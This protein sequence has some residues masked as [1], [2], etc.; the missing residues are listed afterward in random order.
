MSTSEAGRRAEVF[1]PG[2]ALGAACVVFVASLAALVGLSRYLG[3]VPGS[4][5]AHYLDVLFSADTG[6]R[7]LDLTEPFPSH[8]PIAHLLL[9]HIW[10]KPG[11]ALTWASRFVW[12]GDAGRFYGAVGLVCSTAAAGFACLWYCALRLNPRRANLW[13][14]L[15]VCLLFTSNAIIVQPDHFGLS[16]GL[17]SLA[18]LAMLPGARGVGRG[19]LLGL[20]GFLCAVT[21]LT[22][23]LYP[24]LVAA[25][26]H[27][28][29]LT[30]ANAR[31]FRYLI[32]AVA[33]AGALVVVPV[34]VK[35]LPS[36]LRPTGSL[37]DSRITLYLNT[38][39]FSDP[40]GA[41]RYAGSGLLYPAVG[42]SPSTWTSEEDGHVQP[43][44]SY[45]TSTL[46]DYGP[47]SAAA[48]VAWLAL[49]AASGW[50][51]V[52]SPDFRNFSLALL[53]WIVFNLLF[54]NLWGDEFFLF[55][56]HW[57]WALILVVLLGSRGLPVWSVA[58]AALCIIP[59]QLSTLD[60]IRRLLVP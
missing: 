33:A 9:D 32:L 24:A 38:R 53:G 25:V 15:P 27:R 17:V 55:S 37:G 7:W 42:P 8:F 41:L 46:G 44:V 48:A 2:A 45:E 31:R 22:N 30:W 35:R 21:T 50:S 58:L 26:V 12:P 16:F 36:L 47:L 5:Y 59:G 49:L 51:L 6:V 57:S 60:A 4:P 40:L 29:R 18:T 13:I 19:A 56:P 11:A 54:H 23:G 10:G 43:R 3:I 20:T 34:G 39:L 28:D 1:S 52:R 14:L